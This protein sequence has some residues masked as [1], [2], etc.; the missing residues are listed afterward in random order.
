MSNHIIIENTIL[1]KLRRHLGYYNFQEQYQSTIEQITYNKLEQVVPAQKLF[2]IN[3]QQQNHAKIVIAPSFTILDDAWI[4]KIIDTFLSES[5]LFKTYSLKINYPKQN[6][7]ELK[8]TLSILSVSFVE[9]P[10]LPTNFQFSVREQGKIYCLASGERRLESSVAN[11][12]IDNILLLEQK[13]TIQPSPILH[14]II[15]LSPAQNCLALLIATMLHSH[16]R[17]IDVL[18]HTT[19]AQEPLEQARKMCAKYVLLLGEN[20][21]KY[22][23]VIIKNLHSGSVETVAQTQII[24]RI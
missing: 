21:Q 12:Y 24:E 23:T 18:L 6:Y 20:E 15:P 10:T 7:Q 22:G 2:S 17:C 5:L 16:G 11:I 13:I 19:P 8:N 1:D 9:S 3:S 14:V 4:I